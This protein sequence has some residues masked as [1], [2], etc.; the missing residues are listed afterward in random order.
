MEVKTPGAT[1]QAGK[2]YQKEPGGVC[3]FQRV[4]HLQKRGPL[5]VVTLPE[6][7]KDTP[8]E[9]QHLLEEGPEPGTPPTQRQG[10]W[11]SI[12]QRPTATTRGETPRQRGSL[13]PNTIHQGTIPAGKGR[14]LPRGVPP[15]Q[16]ASPTLRRGHRSDIHPSNRGLSQQLEGTFLEQSSLAGGASGKARDGV[17]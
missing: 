15:N 9:D 7:V 8:S 6:T 2:P 4:A 13:S 10:H 5:Q 12:H 1:S 14:N 11:P 3:H 16:R 17:H